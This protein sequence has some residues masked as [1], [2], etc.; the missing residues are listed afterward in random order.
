MLTPIRT[1]DNL[2]FRIDILAG[3]FIFMAVSYLLLK[4]QVFQL[5]PYQIIGAMVFGLLALNLPLRILNNGSSISLPDSLMHLVGIGAG[6]FIY[7]RN[8]FIHKINISISILMILFTSLYGQDFWVHKINYG[9]FKGDVNLKAP[10]LLLLKDSRDQPIDIPKDKIVV[11]DF[12]FIGC[13]ACMD[14]FPEFQKVYNSF[15]DNKSVQFF[16][17]DVPTSRDE[18]NN[19]FTY[20]SNKG[21]S[22][23]MLVSVDKQ[24]NKKM[25]IVGFPTIFILNTK[26]EIVYKGDIKGLTE[27]ISSLL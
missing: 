8:V 24:I 2:G 22:F 15:K 11:M 18:K 5:K 25:Q 13:G 4:K 1:N 17:V 26:G 7:K 19:P 27:R 6:Y 16:S 9:T 21:Y 3:S 10:Q 20:L 12:W 23:P 14:E